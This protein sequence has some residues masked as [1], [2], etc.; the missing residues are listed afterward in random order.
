M[1]ASAHIRLNLE[2]FLLRQRK[3]NSD[4]ADEG[5]RWIVVVHC[6]CCG[7]QWWGLGLHGR[8]NR[9]AAINSLGLPAPP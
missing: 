4:Y 6:V 2:W 5:L 9:F 3:T 8:G 1:C 7:T